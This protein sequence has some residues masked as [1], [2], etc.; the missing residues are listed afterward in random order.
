[1][2]INVSDAAI[3]HELNDNLNS[4]S[5]DVSSTG[6]QA[7]AQGRFA[8]STPNV[9]ITTD[10][11]TE[12]IRAIDNYKNEIQDTL[13]ELETVDS[14]IAFKGTGITEAIRNFVNGVRDTANSY[15]ASL[16]ESQ[17]QIIESVKSAYEE[18]DTDIASNVR[19]DENTVTSASPHHESN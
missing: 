17:Q 19:S 5:V 1:M 18:Q 13:N 6:N 16:K 9:G 15:L 4:T 3:N 2:A 14:E 8:T 12:I 10:M 11:A 7:S